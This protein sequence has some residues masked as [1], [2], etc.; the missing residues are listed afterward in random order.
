MRGWGGMKKRVKHAWKCQ[1]RPFGYF[2]PNSTMH[3]FLY[4]QASTLINYLHDSTSMDTLHSSVHSFTVRRAL[5]D[6]SKFT[7][8]ISINI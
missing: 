7:K 4:A 2:S 3:F 8:C 5:S 1:E 6:N